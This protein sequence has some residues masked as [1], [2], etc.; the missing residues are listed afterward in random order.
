M[1]SL[2]S[3]CVC[4]FCGLDAL[5]LLNVKKLLGQELGDSNY[6]NGNLANEANGPFNSLLSVTNNICW[7]VDFYDTVITVSFF[8]QLKVY[9][10]KNLPLTEKWIEFD[11]PWCTILFFFS[12]RQR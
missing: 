5:K 6:H 2:L 12:E 4:V 10:E 9:I 3:L 1:L 7:S 8:L 11:K